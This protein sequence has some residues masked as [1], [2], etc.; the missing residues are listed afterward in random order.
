MAGNQLMLVK[1]PIAALAVLKARVIHAC[2]PQAALC[3]H[4][5]LTDMSGVRLHLFKNFLVM[6]WQPEKL[7]IGYF[8]IM[9]FKFTFQLSEC[10]S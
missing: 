10:F 2:K 6:L 4:I 8:M 7:D 9:E 3:R 1:K 5:L